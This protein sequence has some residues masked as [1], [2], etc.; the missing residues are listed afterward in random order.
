MT[1]FYSKLAKYYDLIYASK[2][3]KHEAQR[4]HELI[5]RYKTSAG[6][7]LLDVACGTGSHIKYL[8][9]N[10]ET[11]GFDIS[12]EM[13][14]IARKKTK[15][16]PFVQGNMTH[17]DL[18]QQFDALL[19][20]FGSINYLTTMD[21]LTMTIRTFS[22]QTKPGGVIIIE[23]VFT[24]ETFKSGH[25]GILC[26]DEPEVK[27]ARVNVN[28]R[29]GTIVHFDFHFLIATSEG[30][31]HFT[32]SSPVGLFSRTDFKT[33]MENNGFTFKPIEPGLSHSE[34]YIGVNTN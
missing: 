7:N 21:E 22:N 23:P 15:D 31:E 28:R 13:L 3:Y 6:N 12:E 34:L 2:N 27:I 25:M 16:V 4:L 9:V 11:M 10:Y 17:L 5:Q 30:T 8:K 26:I 1:S 20:L 14:A 29:E 32:D 24:L 19:C 18:G 33:I